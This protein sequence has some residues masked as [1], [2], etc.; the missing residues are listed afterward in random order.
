VQGDLGQVVNQKTAKF[1][2]IPLESLDSGAFLGTGDLDL[3]DD[4][5]IT[6]DSAD[7]GIALFD[8]ESGISLDLDDT[9]TQQMSKVSPNLSKGH[10]DPGTLEMDVPLAGGNDS[11]FELAG[12]DDDDD[13]F[14]T[15]TSVLMFDDDDAADGGFSVASQP[16]VPA[17]RGDLDMED[18]GGEEVFEDD[19][20]DDFD[21]FEEEEMDGVWDAEDQDE[22]EDFDSGESQVGGSAITKTAGVAAGAGAWA[23]DRPWGAAWTSAVSVAA[24]MS[25]LSAFVGIELVR[26]MWMMNQPGQPASGLLSMLGGMFGK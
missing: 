16:A 22:D 14:G 9:R 4:S 8:D 24:L 17:R 11:E 10:S 7:S 1:R 5:G 18:F 2:R 15:D 25:A 6:L 13:D 21:D 12:L 19:L 26:T 20:G 23:D 3:D